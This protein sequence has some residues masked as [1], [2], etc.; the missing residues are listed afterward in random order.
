MPEVTA[1]V[2]LGE[3]PPRGCLNLRGDPDRPGFLDAVAD[4]LGA[5]PPVQPCTWHQAGDTAAYWLGPD[6]W[7]V[8]VLP[9]TETVLERSLRDRLEGSFSIVDT[10]GNQVWMH[11]AGPSALQVLGKSSP[12]DFHPR[13]FTPGRCVQT[14]FAKASALVAAHADGSVDLAVRRSFADYLDRWIADAAEEYG[15][16]DKTC[17]GP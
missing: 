4:V 1:G 3:G 6:D 2:V 16:T 15:F 12:Y 8:S 11:L 10:T 5:R 7:M 13:N 9:G 17:R 14:T